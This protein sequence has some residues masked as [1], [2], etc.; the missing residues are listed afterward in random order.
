MLVPNTCG[1]LC[2]HAF[3]SSGIAVPTSISY[4]TPLYFTW[5]ISLD[6][7]APSPNCDINSRRSISIIR[8]CSAIN[9]SKLSTPSLDSLWVEFRRCRYQSFCSAYIRIGI[10]EIAFD[11]EFHYYSC[12]RH[13]LY[14]GIV[15]FVIVW[16]GWNLFLP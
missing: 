1:G 5:A 3:P 8:W 2:S 13:S 12:K 14:I 16:T 7:T 4:I 9:M 10:V 11:W 15:A 6:V